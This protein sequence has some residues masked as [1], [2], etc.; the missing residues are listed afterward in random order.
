MAEI[1][2][3][4]GNR[5]SVRQSAAHHIST[6][7]TESGINY[8]EQNRCLTFLLQTQFKIIMCL[9]PED[10]NDYLENSSQRH[11]S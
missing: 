9:S 3:P 2:E 5:E 6:A 8:R 11:A 1:E 10:C 4:C 7:E